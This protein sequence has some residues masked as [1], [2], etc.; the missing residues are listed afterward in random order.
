[1][2]ETYVKPTAASVISLLAMIYGDELNAS[3]LDSASVSGQRIATFI[4]DDDELVAACV[5]DREFVVYSGAA[6]AMIPAGGAQDMIAENSISEAISGNFHE[7]MNICTKLL[8][9]DSSAHLRLDKTLDYAQQAEL[10]TLAT[11]LGFQVD[12]PGYGSGSMAIYMN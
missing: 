9:S 5:C 8:M 12:I 10:D 6:L 7:V 4:N 1:M 11:R 3:D 2:S